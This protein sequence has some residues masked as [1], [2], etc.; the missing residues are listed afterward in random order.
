MHSLLQVSGLIDRINER[1]SKAAIWLVLVVT[2]IGA[3]NA[4]VRKVF[5]MSS[6][7]F[8]EI[9]WYL[10]SA[11]FLLCAAHAL[12]KNVHVRIDVVAGRF[13][14]RTQAW[15]DVF[16]TLFFLFPMAC[17]IFWLSADVFMD[18][19]RSGE[20]SASAGGL[21][22]WPA[23][24]LVP[25]GF[26]MV[27][28]QGCSELIKRVAFLS[29]K[30]PDPLGEEDAASPEEQLAADIVRAQADKQKGKD[31]EAHA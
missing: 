27:I 14:R 23:R 7:A 12:Q 6:N 28:L 20:R 16:G 11:I 5:D 1:I 22:L 21:I 3:G 18:A 24:L 9:Q 31:G 2:L 4:V 17:I 10:F 29:G 19:F 13:S 26:A 25:V 8:L 15:I 30:G